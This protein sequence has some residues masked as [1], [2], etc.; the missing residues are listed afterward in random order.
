[1]RQIYFVILACMMMIK[2]YGGLH[3]SYKYLIENTIWV[4]PPSTLLAYSYD[5]DSVSA[6]VDQTVWIID[7]YDGGFFTGQAYTGINGTSTLSQK[8]MLGSITN[9]GNVYITFYSGSAS[10]SG[11]VSGIGIFKKEQG[12]YCFIM[13]MNSGSA[14]QGISHWSYMV[15][16]TP[17]SAYYQDLPGVGLSVPEFLDLFR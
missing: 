10:P 2:G 9:N 13:Q 17:D 4:V 16:V 14:S 3:D 15:S 12:N 11:L 7:S 5:S 6:E 1:M 8:S